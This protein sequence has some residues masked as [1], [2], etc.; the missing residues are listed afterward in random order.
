MTTMIEP[1]KPSGP[2]RVEQITA[3]QDVYASIDLLA[4]PAYSDFS[5]NPNIALHSRLA[6]GKSFQGFA[7]LQQFSPDPISITNSSLDYYKMAGLTV[8]QLDDQILADIDLVVANLSVFG[9]LHGSVTDLGVSGFLLSSDAAPDAMY[10]RLAAQLSALMQQVIV[11]GQSLFVGILSELATEEDRRTRE[12][13]W[14][15]ENRAELE[16]AEEQTRLAEELDAIDQF[17]ADKTED[18]LAQIEATFNAVYDELARQ[19]Q[20]HIDL[21]VQKYSDI[22]NRDALVIDEEFKQMEFVCEREYL[23]NSLARKQ[24]LSRQIDGLKKMSDAA[25]QELRA[26]VNV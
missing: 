23:E 14:Q 13:E 9:Y 24:V 1:R 26:Y 19:R 4:F 6:L 7:F 18:S 10:L 12:T 8:E 5:Q 20:E 16:D 11:H 21:L 25:M 17:W 22:M 2:N 15:K 3:I